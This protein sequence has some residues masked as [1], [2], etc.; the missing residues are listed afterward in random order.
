MTP[1]ERVLESWR[2]H[3]REGW[4]TEKCVL[5]VNETLLEMEIAS[6]LFTYPIKWTTGPSDRP[7]P[8]WRKR[9]HVF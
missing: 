2:E 1:S 6:R 4:E 9:V 7:V 3:A 5:A 8:L